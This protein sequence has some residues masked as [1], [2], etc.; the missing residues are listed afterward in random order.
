MQSDEES[1]T[2]YKENTTKNISSPEINLSDNESVNLESGSQKYPSP[3]TKENM[4]SADS[5]ND[6]VS[7]VESQSE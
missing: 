5:S 3:R 6:Q 4:S 1:D 7:N 2:G